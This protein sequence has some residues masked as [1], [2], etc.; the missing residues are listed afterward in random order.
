MIFK[1]GDIG[2]LTK[3]KYQEIVNSDFFKS[4]T[5]DRETTMGN[6]E[7]KVKERSN[8]HKRRRSNTH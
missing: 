7:I 1:F 3:I 6:R 8:N 4:T 2:F 5:R